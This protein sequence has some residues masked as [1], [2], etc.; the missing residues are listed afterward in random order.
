MMN[1]NQPTPSPHPAEKITD[2]ATAYRTGARFVAVTAVT[3]CGDPCHFIT[4]LLCGQ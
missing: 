3:A 2:L 1:L 4:S